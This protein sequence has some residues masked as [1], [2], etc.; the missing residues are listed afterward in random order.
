MIFV[1]SRLI[2]GD[3]ARLF[4]GPDATDA[5]VQ[6]LR[7]EWGLDKPIYVQYYI[8]LNELVHG[9]LGYSLHFEQPVLALLKGFL[10]ATLELTSTA[11]I[12]ALVFG[13]PLGILAA[14]HRNKFLD[15]FSRVLSLI[16]VSIPE[17][18]SGI[19]LQLAA[20]ALVGTVLAGRWSPGVIPPHTVTGL[21]TIDS[22]L[23]GSWKDLGITLQHLLPPA[24]ILSLGVFAES[25]EARALAI[26]PK[27]VCS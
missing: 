7:N 17:F 27:T 3:P 26:S 24:A 1:I 13:V 2:P 21:Y 25:R 22:I 8:Y 12:I 10:P 4:L 5:Q 18:W 16:G 23:A 11:M 15:S 20:F 19:L 14:T 6:A 9:N